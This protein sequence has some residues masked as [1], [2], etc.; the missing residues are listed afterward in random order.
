MPAS[1]LNQLVSRECCCRQSLEVKVLRLLN[2]DPNTKN[3]SI[4]KR[5]RGLVFLADSVA[6]VASDAQAVAG[7]SELSCLRAHRPAGDGLVV[8]VQ[9]SRAQGLVVFARFLPD[10]FHPQRILAGFEFGR[11]E[12]LF[13][14]DAEEVVHVI[15][16]LIF[17]E[18][19]MA[20][21]SRTVGEDHSRRLIRK[22]QRPR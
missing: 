15:Q 16:L 6:A 4:N 8:H 18:Q 7:E 19:R 5:S 13:R 21:K 3:F 22:F 9:C 10:E 17:D 1:S 14:L 20:A 11:D 12:L 2:T